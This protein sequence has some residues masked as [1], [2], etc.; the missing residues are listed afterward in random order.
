MAVFIV[1]IDGS[2]VEELFF[3][4]GSRL[5]GTLMTAASRPGPDLSP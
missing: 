3:T 5:L 2:E 1:S 4:T